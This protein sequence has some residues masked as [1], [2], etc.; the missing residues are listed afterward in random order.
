MRLPVSGAFHTK[1]MK[2]AVEILRSHFNKI[3]FQKPAIPVHSNFDGKRYSSAFHIGRLLLQQIT[4]PVKWEQTLHVLTEYK[5]ESKLPN[6]Y[7]CGPGKSLS[8]I[9]KMV[10]LKAECHSYDV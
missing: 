1:L 5:K 4:H 9:L 8:T 3:D 7:E 6:I 2:P 10:N